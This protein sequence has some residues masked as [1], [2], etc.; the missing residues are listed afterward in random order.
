MLHA[1]NLVNFISVFKI[2]KNRIFIFVKIS[3]ILFYFIFALDKSHKNFIYYSPRKMSNLLNKLALCLIVSLMLH[4]M[5]TISQTEQFEVANVE[6]DSV[7][8]NEIY[9]RNEMVKILSQI[10]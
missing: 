6:S 9:K 5:I 3:D 7:E 2:N 1:N 4:L 8:S 10:I